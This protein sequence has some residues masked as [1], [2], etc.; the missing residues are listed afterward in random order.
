MRDIRSEVEPVRLPGERAADNASR[1]GH[2]RS[3]FGEPHGYRIRAKLLVTP[4]CKEIL[5]GDL[6][7]RVSSIGSGKACFNR[8]RINGL[9]EPDRHRVEPV[10]GDLIICKRIADELSGIGGIGTSTE[11]VEEWLL[12]GEVA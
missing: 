6:R 3:E 5:I 2:G 4:H 12:S 10:R 8:R 9:R 7:A 11:R 1:R